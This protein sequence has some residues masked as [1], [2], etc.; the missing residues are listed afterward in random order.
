VHQQLYGTENVDGVDVGAYART[1][2]TALQGS[3]DPT[4]R[5]E[6]SLAVVEV[7]IDVAVPCALVLNE[8][9]TNA[10]KHGRSADGTCRLTVG[11]ERVDDG[12]VLTV[13]DEGPGMPTRAKASASLGM[14]LV[15]SLSRQLR[16]RV[17]FENDGGTRARLRVPLPP[18]A[19]S[20]S[21]RPSTS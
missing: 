13:K 21:G 11:V 8:L 10:L 6:F 9:V 3:L 5:I 18:S 19:P 14:Q 20:D 15:R 17:D 7:A 2:V 16:G 12:V 4:A 1:L